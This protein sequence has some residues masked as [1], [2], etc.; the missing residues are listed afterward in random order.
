[1]N[2]CAPGRDGDPPMSLCPPIEEPTIAIAYTVGDQP[3]IWSADPVNPQ[4]C[5]GSQLDTRA[6]NISDKGWKCMAVATADLN[7]NKSVSA[8][9]RVWVDYSDNRGF[10]AAPAV[11]PSTAPP[12]TGTYDAT[13]HTATVGVCHTRKFEDLN[14]ICFNGVCPGP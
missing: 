6:N 5:V 14:E 7:G 13:T 1:M 10:C 8:A 11:A 3:A 12:C 2:K 4:Y 9:I